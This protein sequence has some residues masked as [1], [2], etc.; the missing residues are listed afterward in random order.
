MCKHEGENYE[1]EEKRRENVIAE[2][3][4]SREHKNRKTTR[5]KKMQNMNQRKMGRI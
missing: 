5:T 1:R 2:R 4:D 3:A